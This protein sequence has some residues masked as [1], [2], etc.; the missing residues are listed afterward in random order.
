MSKAR[1]KL[2]SG[3]LAVGYPS[4][5]DEAVLDAAGVRCESALY[6]F[7]SDG[8]AAG[9]IS[10]GRNLPAGAI[11][12]S[13]YSDEQ[14]AFTSGGS[15]TIQLKAGSTNLTDALAFDTAFTGRD[16]QA[17]A[18]SAEAIK[19]SSESELKITIA[20]AALTAGKCRFFVQYLLPND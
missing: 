20:A 15:A 12:V 3:N 4:R 10:F 17:L 2:K 16:S 7:S 9:D 14:T 1:R 13:I 5:R 11:V 6:D 18:S 8:G 19:V